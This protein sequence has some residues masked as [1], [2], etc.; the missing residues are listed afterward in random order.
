[1][2]ESTWSGAPADVWAATWVSGPCPVDGFGGESGYS[3]A[4]VQV[5]DGPRLQVLVDGS[6]APAPGISGRV[7]THAVGDQSIDLFTPDAGAV[8]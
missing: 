6:D 2:T 1:M 8:V 3:V 4:W 7:S 5:S